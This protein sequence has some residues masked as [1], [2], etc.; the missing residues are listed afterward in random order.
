MMTRYEAPIAD[1]IALDR[2]DIL[3]LSDNGTYDGQ[4]NQIS[5]DKLSEGLLP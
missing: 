4:S 1:L 3:T 2:A 5:W